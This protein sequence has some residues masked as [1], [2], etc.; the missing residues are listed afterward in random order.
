MNS[1]NEQEE[2]LKDD[3]LKLHETVFDG[4]KEKLQELLE[5]GEYDVNKKDK[6]GKV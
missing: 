6:F 1:S 2:D 4:D 5:S 3:Q